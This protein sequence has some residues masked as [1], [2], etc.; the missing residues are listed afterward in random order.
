MLALLS[1]PRCASAQGFLRQSEL[2]VTVGGLNYIGDL[3]HQHLNGPVRP[4]AGLFAR[5]R[6]GERWA[7][8]LGVN[9]GRVVGGDPDIDRLRNLSFRS[10]II[11][12]SLRMEFNFVPFGADGYCFRTSPYLFVGLGFLHFNPQACYHN[13]ATDSDE[14]VDLQPLHTEGQ[15]SG[16]YPDRIPYSLMQM[17]LPFGLGFKMALSKD[18]TLAVEYGYRYTWT[19]YL[20]DVS[21]TYVGGEVLG[22]GSVAEALADRS[23]EIQPGYVNAVGIQ[24]GD[25]SL[26][27]AYAFFN[28]SLTISMET[29]FGWMRSKKCEIK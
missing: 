6:M 5:Y 13:P 25:D 4:A 26:N 27:D 8:T 29:L 16:M 22:S 20:D 2:G 9:Y 15:G 21:T 11:E 1:L 17:V 3:N 14:W 24:R 10:H 23:S 12:A 7:A 18:V 19:D 28:M